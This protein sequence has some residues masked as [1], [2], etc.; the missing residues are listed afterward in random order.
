ME[1]LDRFSKAITIVERYEQYLYQ[2]AMGLAFIVNGLV[3]PAV[4]FLI[5]KAEVFSIYLGMTR[6]MF[7]V[8][9]TTLL[10]GIGVLLNIFLFAS[11]RVLSSRISER[12][13]YRDLP[14]MFLMFSIWFVAFFLVGYIPDPYSRVGWSLAGGAAS[15][16]SYLV[17]S[18][19]GH[20][21]RPELIIIG[22]INIL[23]ILPIYLYGDRLELEILVLTIYAISF[24]LGGAYSTIKANQY[25]EAS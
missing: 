23:A 1:N 20:Q 18:Y 11:A 5:L 25:L 17:L 9:S 3:G 8:I 16:I 24:V 22:V 10:A 4:F 15:L 12:K 14:F 21:K 2:R 6:T 7:S 19:S 13:D